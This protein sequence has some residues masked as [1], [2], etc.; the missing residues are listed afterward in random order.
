M[1]I[2]PSV[3]TYVRPQ[4][5]SSISV[6]LGM[7]VDVDEWCTTVCIMTDPRSRSRSRALHSWKSGHFQKLS[8]LPFT[9]G[10]GK[11]PLILKLGHNISICSGRIFDIWPNFCVTWLWTW[12]LQRVDRQSRTGLTVDSSQLTFLWHWVTP[13]NPKPAHFQRF[14]IFVV[15]ADR[16]FNFGRQLI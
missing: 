5:V 8:P 7:L 15:S 16:N 4:K 1:S 12:H 3:R 13:N 6:K 2:R 9:M 11:W 10:A 14:H